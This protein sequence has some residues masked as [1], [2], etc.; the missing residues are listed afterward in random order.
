MAMSS[1]VPTGSI[2]EAGMRWDEMSEPW[3]DTDFLFS[4][5]LRSSRKRG[6]RAR[7]P[8]PTAFGEVGGTGEDEEEEYDDSEGGGVCDSGGGESGLE[9]S[10]LPVALLRR[11]SAGGGTAPFFRELCFHEVGGGCAGCNCGW[12]FTT[13]TLGG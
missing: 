13:A 1:M 2:L 9:V 4:V 3:R 7:E 8:V 5:R 6:F 10:N 11:F 12:G